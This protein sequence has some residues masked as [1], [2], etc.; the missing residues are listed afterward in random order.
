MKVI[1]SLF[2]KKMFLLFLSKSRNML[3]ITYGILFSARL[4]F[5]HRLC[6]AKEP[7]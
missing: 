2:L 1:S 7:F 3:L 5:C 6:D 4:P